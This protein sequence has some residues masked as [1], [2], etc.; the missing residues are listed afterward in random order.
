MK[1]M[2]TLVLGSLLLI[3][4]AP[5]F[6]QTTGSLTGRA[7]DESGG[8][9][10]GVTVEAKSPALQGARGA[11]TDARA[12]PAD[13]AAAGHYTVAFTLPAS[14]RR[15][16]PR[17]RSASATRRTLDS[18]PAV[19]DGGDHRHRRGAGRRHDA[20]RRSAPTSTRRTIQTLPTGRNYSSVVQIAP[21][22]LLRRRP[23]RTRRSRRSPSTAPPAPRTRSSSTASTRRASS[24]A[25]R[26]RSSTSSSSRRSTSRPAATRPST[27][28]RPAASST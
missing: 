4:A 26:A 18:A 12:L 28:A 19:R 27:A 25:S 14:R 15:R 23:R 11:V 5:L 16:A 8:V 2:R 6:A 9:L 1:T 7:L 22:R 24:T 20:R 13:A 21:G 17:S 3:G 10:P